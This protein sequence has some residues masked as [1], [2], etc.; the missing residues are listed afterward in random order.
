M[1]KKAKKEKE[2]A[3]EREMFEYLYNQVKKEVESPG[4]HKKSL[5]Q[6]FVFEKMLQDLRPLISNSQ[7]LLE[8]D[9]WPEG[10]QDFCLQT[11][12]AFSFF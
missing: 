10:M 7:Y 1:G 9:T 2:D 6:K 11:H 5:K 3:L 8:W 4:L 12:F